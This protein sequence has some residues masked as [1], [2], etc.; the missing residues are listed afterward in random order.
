M[1]DIDAKLQFLIDNKKMKDLKKADIPEQVKN[2]EALEG[3]AFEGLR[4][5]LDAQK[6]TTP[7]EYSIVKE[8]SDE[9]IL[10]R[11]AA[12]EEPSIV[13]KIKNS[14]LNRNVEAAAPT[15]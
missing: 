8:L 1:K 5:A 14:L 15:V 6:S 10:A 7:P 2:N 9:E 3:K 13:D 12:E 4:E 11:M